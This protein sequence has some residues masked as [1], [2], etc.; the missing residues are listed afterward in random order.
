MRKKLAEVP[1]LL[2]ALRKR[3]AGLKR[4]NSVAR[5]LLVNDRK[6]LFYTGLSSATVFNGLL[7][8]FRPKVMKMQYWRGPKLSCTK[9]ATRHY[10]R[11]PKKPGPKR[12]LFIIDEFLI[13]LMKLRL[14]APMDDLADRFGI[15]VS[16][17]SS[18][19]NTWIRIMSMHFKE[20]IFFPPRDVVMNTMPQQ[21]RDKK[22]KAR[23][24]I[25][26]T[27]V[28][29]ERPHNLRTQALTWS[30]Y[31]SH[32]TVKFLVGVTPH[33][34]ISFLS[35]AWGGRTSNTFRRDYLF[36]GRN[37]NR[38]TCEEIYKQH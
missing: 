29:I 19:F 4:C 27:E 8:Y 14:D 15:S 36:Y 20:L 9:S 31:K 24:I 38:F 13:T 28:F 33:G 11:S 35:S 23:V 25:D 21:F 7:Q 10:K 22:C 26:C 18:I 3:C 34:H 1:S 12:K 5:Q 16:T 2:L 6:V 32:N 17:A 37:L 30:D